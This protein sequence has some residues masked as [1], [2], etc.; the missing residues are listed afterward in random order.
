MIP[1]FPGAT[2]QGKSFV[3]SR[4]ANIL[5]SYQLNLLRSLVPLVDVQHFICA[6]VFPLAKEVKVDQGQTHLRS[7]KVEAASE[8]SHI[9]LNGAE[10]PHNQSTYQRKFESGF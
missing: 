10:D 2:V 7:P 1:I 3:H 6:L 9:F 5:P 8:Q 4:Y